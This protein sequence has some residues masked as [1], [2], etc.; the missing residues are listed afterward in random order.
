M[1]NNTANKNQLQE[2]REGLIYEQFQPVTA[3]LYQKR[4]DCG[5]VCVS[6]APVQPRLRRAVRAKIL[7]SPNWDPQTK[8]IRFRIDGR[9]KVMGQK[10]FARDIRAVDMPH[11]PQKQ[12]HACI[13]RVTKADRLFEGSIFRCWG[14]TCSRIAW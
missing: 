1:R 5:G 12:A 9:A 13:L 14:T 7:Q 11:W 2:R 10:V 8:R 3:P 4:R 6:R